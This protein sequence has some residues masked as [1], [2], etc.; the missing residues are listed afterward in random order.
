MYV[1]FYFSAITMIHMHTYTDNVC[2]DLQIHLFDV[3]LFILNAHHSEI[4]REKIRHWC[5][6]VT[7][8]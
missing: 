1:Y 6:N 8:I 5:F 4:K 7:H 2:N 3:C